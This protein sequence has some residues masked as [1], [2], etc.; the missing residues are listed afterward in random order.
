M[1]DNLYLENNTDIV[2]TESSNEEMVGLFNSIRVGFL[3]IG[4][5]PLNSDYNA[6]QNIKCNNSCTSTIFEPNHRNHTALSI[7]RAEKFGVT[8]VDTEPFPTYGCIK[9]GGPIFIA[10][11]VSG[12]PKL[13]Y[14]FFEL[15][16][17]ITKEQITNPLFELPSGITK[18]RLYLWIEGQDIDSLETDSEGAKIDI[19]INFL[20]DTAGY[21]EY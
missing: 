21:T 13:D 18:V 12:S 17:T 8:L 10:D 20:K 7:E 6:V 14:D 19:S 16:Q 11:T 4:S 15:Q 2:L 1:S 3:K 9:S 5:L